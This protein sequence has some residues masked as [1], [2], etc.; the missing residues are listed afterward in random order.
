MWSSVYDSPLSRWFFDHYYDKVENHFP[1]LQD[2]HLL[3]AGCGTGTLEIRLAQRFPSATILGIDI[4]EKM[5]QKAM[6]KKKD[7]VNVH[8]TMS[9]SEHLEFPDD[10]LD[11]IVCIHSFHHYAN[12]RASLK[13]FKRVLKPGGTLYWLDGI[14]DEW[15]GRLHLKLTVWILS[16]AFL[17]VNDL[18]TIV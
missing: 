18:G 9:I 8:F 7:R 16:I 10:S 11:I 3:S 12:Q 5:L 17:S 4:S 1:P 14:K 15:L 2:Q 13:E 6:T